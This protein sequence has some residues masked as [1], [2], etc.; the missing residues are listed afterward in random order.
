VPDLVANALIWRS[1]PTS[2]GYGG[3]RNLSPR[4]PPRMQS[5][6]EFSI[7]SVFLEIIFLYGASVMPEIA[8]VLG[9]YARSCAG[10]F[11]FT[12]PLD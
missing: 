9:K 4:P 11:L 7:R 2:Q 3:R 6:M 8:A 5:R 12:S 10:E 1:I